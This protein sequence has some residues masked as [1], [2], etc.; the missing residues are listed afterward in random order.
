MKKSIS[1]LTEN[2]KIVNKDLTKNYF[3]SQGFI[4][5]DESEDELNFVRGNYLLNMVT[6]DPLK[7]KSNIVITFSDNLI[8][9]VFSI[10][11]FGQTVSKKEEALW[12]IFISNLEQSILEKKDLSSANEILLSETQKSSFKLVGLT[13]LITAIVGIPSGI[14]AHYTGNDRIFFIG[15]SLGAS[16]FFILKDKV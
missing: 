15:I 9:A 13:I 7:W 6:F 16:S 3:I 14:I 11:T 1:F 4:L 5:K 12:N 2:N 8:R 10:S